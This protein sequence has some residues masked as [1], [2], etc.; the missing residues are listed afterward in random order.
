MLFLNEKKKNCK[1]IFQ[2]NFQLSYKFSRGYTTLK[3][4]HRFLNFML[5]NYGEI[6]F[7]PYKT[8]KNIRTSLT[9][10]S[11]ITLCYE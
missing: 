4:C 1:I 2:Q 8:N 5:L 11:I 10:F 9:F 3:A 6:N 7:K